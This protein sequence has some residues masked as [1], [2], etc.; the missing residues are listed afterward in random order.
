M[1]FVNSWTGIFKKMTGNEIAGKYIL[2]ITGDKMQKAGDGASLA[3]YH[4][5]LELPAS[6]NVAMLSV[7]HRTSTTTEIE[8]LKIKDESENIFDLCG[9]KLDKM[10]ESGV[11]IKNNKKIYIR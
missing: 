6:A 9:R 7:S 8:N 11:V 5:Y 1:E 4:C 3:P 10:P 2:N